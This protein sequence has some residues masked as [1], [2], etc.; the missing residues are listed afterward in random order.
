M[1]GNIAVVAG[2]PD[3]GKTAYLLNIVKDNQHA[4]EIHY[5][6]SE[7]GA[8]ELRSRLELFP[9]IDINQW[10]FHAKER[11]ANFQD[12][13][14]PDGFNIIDFLEI[15]DAFYT[16]GGML[17]SIHDRLKDGV[18]VIAIQKGKGVELGRGGSFSVE[19]PRLYLS[20]SNDY[21][22]HSI[23]IVK[24]KNWRTSENPNGLERRFK[25]VNGCQLIEL[26]DWHR[27]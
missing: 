7:M 16:I 2:E 20:L 13:I 27:Q 4:H 19:K 26:N 12:V 25:L 9:D 10:S 1:P 17:K 11:A 8:M 3:S 15:H 6:S 24:C 22:G 14:R 23:K 21:P 5:F 18:A